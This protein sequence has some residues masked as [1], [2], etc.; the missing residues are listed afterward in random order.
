MKYCVMAISRNSNLFLMG[1]ERSL[2]QK[3]IVIVYENI[4]VKPKE[5]HEIFFVIFIENGKKHTK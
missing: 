3:E 2:S 5:I 1:I 4:P